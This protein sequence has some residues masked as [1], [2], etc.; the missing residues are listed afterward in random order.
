MISLQK[1]KK[2]SIFIE[3][4][5]GTA[6][7][8]KKHSTTEQRYRFYIRKKKIIKK[9]RNKEKKEKKKT[10]F[11]NGKAMAVH[12]VRELNCFFFF[13]SLRLLSSEYYKDTLYLATVLREK[14]IRKTKRWETVRRKEIETRIIYN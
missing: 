11:N 14:G 5:A 1:K 2:N 8:L 12:V 9:K 13:F 4:L 3:G 10:D 6:I 7:P